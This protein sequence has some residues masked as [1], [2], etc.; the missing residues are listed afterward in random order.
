MQ[1]FV[2]VS[3]NPIMANHIP[4]SMWKDSPHTI[5]SKWVLRV[6]YWAPII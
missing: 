3:S 1:Y 4:D 6:I 5:H 2:D